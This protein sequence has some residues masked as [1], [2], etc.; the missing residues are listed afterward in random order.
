MHNITIRRDAILYNTTVI[1]KRAV[2]IFDNSF[3][4][5][6]LLSVASFREYL[7][8]PITLI[9]IGIPDSELIDS[10]KNLGDDIEFICKHVASHTNK[11]RAERHRINRFTRM[12][13]MR[14][15]PNEQV[16]LLDGDL[17]F[18]NRIKQL[19]EFIDIRFKNT[20][21][22]MVWGVT[23]KDRRRRFFTVKIDEMGNRFHSNEDE[24][25]QCLNDVYGDNWKKRLSGV[26]YNNGMLILYN[27]AQ[28]ADAWQKN[29]LKGLEHPSVNHE[30]D[31]L[32]LFV[33]MFDLNAETLEM[34]PTFNS[35]GKLSGTYATY[36]AWAG[37]WKN[38]LKKIE[39]KEENLEDYGHIAL[40]FYDK[41]PQSWVLKMPLNESNYSG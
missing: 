41:L 2:W 30:D 13:V 3:K 14:T 4:I 18:S 39:N 27:C 36:H 6:T 1:K 19:T 23:E 29:Y 26:Q 8:I 35:L 11:R 20:N 24:I 31:Q 32:P 7:D 33:A 37:S 5:P 15:W 16:I 28:L 12:E 10:F 25:H 38:E 34:D 9:Y 21:K 22:P 40:K 17:I